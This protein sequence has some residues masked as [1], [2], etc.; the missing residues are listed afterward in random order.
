MRV[1]SFDLAVDLTESW[2]TAIVEDIDAD[3]GIQ[4]QEGYTHD[5]MSSSLSWDG[6]R[7]QNE[8]FDFS[9]YMDQVRHFNFLSDSYI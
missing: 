4:F 8:L 6:T 9:I 7:P 5:M 3:K 1:F 2:H